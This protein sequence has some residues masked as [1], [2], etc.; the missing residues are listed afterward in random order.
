MIAWRATLA[1]AVLWAAADP[2]VAQDTAD[3]AIDEARQQCEAFENG[4]FG[5]TDEVLARID[6]S[7]DGNPD[8]LVDGHGFRCSSGNLYCG[9]GGCPLIAIVEGTRTDF[10][11]KAWRVVE[12]GPTQVLLLQVHG[13]GCG[14]TNLRTCVEAVVWSEGAFRS[15]RG[16]GS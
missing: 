5:T 8:L 9:T 11:A 1:A 3:Q 4:R 14:G 6:L 16:D 2:A 15:V 13:V 7:G 12:W 10:L